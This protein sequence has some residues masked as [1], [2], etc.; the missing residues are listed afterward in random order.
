M[1]LL[2]LILVLP[3]IA[4][5]N[6]YLRFLQK[7]SLALN[8]SDCWVCGLTP[9]TYDE[10]F[11]MIPR[12]L[13]FMNLTAC[14]EDL[15]HETWDDAEYLKVVPEQGYFCWVRNQ[16]KKLNY[17]VGNSSCK[18]YTTY[19]GIWMNNHTASKTWCKGFKNWY[20][21]Y[22]QTNNRALS[23][24]AIK[25]FNVTIWDCSRADQGHCYRNGTR[26]S[27]S[28]MGA[29]SGIHSPFGGWYVRYFGSELGKPATETNTTWVALKGTY[30]VCGTKAY[31][32]LPPDWFGSCYLAWL[33]PAVRITKSLPQGRHRNR[34]E[35]P[36]LSSQEQ[37]AQ[38]TLETYKNPLTVGKLI[39]CSAAEIIPPRTRPAMSCV[40]RY[41]LQLQSVAEI[42]ALETETAINSLGKNV[43]SV[44]KHEESL[45]QMV[46]QN[47]LAL[48]YV[49][50]SE[51][52]ACAV[53]GRECCTYVNSTYKLVKDHINNAMVHADKAVEVASIPKDSSA[54]WFPWLDP[55]GL[56]KGLLGKIMFALCMVLILG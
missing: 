43:K 16:S 23:C 12:P 33:T 38:A 24:S 8:A 39:G 53:I 46:I 17:S 47:R 9:R 30:W 25:S 5:T 42:L 7:V 20:T 10:G 50:A 36:N 37:A 54:D 13:T 56:F 49:S 19:D 29:V 14:S 1:R 35:S 18:H 48:D 32:Q 4:S 44:A 45:R 2:I 28:P 55:R 52:G 34:R 6:V 51:G 11:L 22:N 40:G 3:A 21:T 41:T 31:H 15:N 27:P 26:V